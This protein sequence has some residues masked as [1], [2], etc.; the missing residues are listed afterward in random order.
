M[1]RLGVA[2]PRDLVQ[3]GIRREYAQRLLK[4]GV[5]VRVGR[6]LY[7]AP[8]ADISSHRSL[9]EVTKAVP[10]GTICLLRLWGVA[11]APQATCRG[12]CNERAAADP[13]YFEPLIAV[14]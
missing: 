12:N 11:G 13:T 2:R 6:G 10:K 3:L 14:R 1:R 5:L 9:A 4:R 8:D 7:A